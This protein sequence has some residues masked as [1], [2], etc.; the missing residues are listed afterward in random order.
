MDKQKAGLALNHAMEITEK[1]WKMFEGGFPAPASMNNLYPKIAN[2]DWT[3][4]FYTGMLWLFYEYSHRPFFRELA[5]KQLPDFRDRLERRVVVDHHDMGFIF[6]LSC[7]AAYKLTGNE[8]ARETALIAAD[9]LK[10]RFHEKG[11]FIQAWGLLG[12]PN[13]Y[14]LIIDCL[15]NLPLLYWASEV[16]GDPSYRICAEKHFDTARK[17]VIREDFSTYHTYYFDKETG[18]PSYGATKQGYS[19]SSTWSRGQAWGVYGLILNYAWQKDSTILPEWKGVTDYFIDHLPEDL[20]AYWDFHFRDG[21]EPRDSSASAIAVCGIQEAYRQGGC[22]KA[23]LDK[24]YEILDSLVDNYAAKP[25]EKGN[26][27]LKHATYGRLLGEGVD[28]FSLWGDY[29]Y[30]EAL[31]RVIQPDWKMYW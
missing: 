15:L 28:E 5:E 17:T 31:Y 13:E 20:T 26:G 12:D 14:R 6:G 22:D 19:D 25:E 23:Y 29:F 11:Q 24:A 30:V 21:D 9:N 2:N 27:L 8:S 10:S 3:A 16:T 7:V 1:N 4:G 18:M